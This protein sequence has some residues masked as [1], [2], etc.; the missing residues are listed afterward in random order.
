MQQSNDL[1]RIKNWTKKKKRWWQRRGWWGRSGR[2]GC[3]RPCGWSPI[4]AGSRRRSALGRGFPLIRGRIPRSSLE[5]IAAAAQTSFLFSWSLPMEWD[6]PTL[7]LLL[8]VFSFWS[9]VSF[10][11][12]RSLLFSHRACLRMVTG[13]AMTSDC[14]LGPFLPSR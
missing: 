14:K 3:R 4:G 9:K 1:A 6:Q 7:L 2:R 13:I 11:G 5:C 8:L 12:Y 10:M